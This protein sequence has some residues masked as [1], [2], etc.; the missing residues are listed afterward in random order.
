MSYKESF[1]NK[2]YLDLK[3]DW[4]LTYKASLGFC[5]DSRRGLP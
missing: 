3:L 4:G 1:I 5:G 2:Y